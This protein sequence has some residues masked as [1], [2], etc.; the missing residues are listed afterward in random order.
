MLNYINAELY[1]NFNRKY[2]WMYT[3]I[4]VALAI[5]A[6]IAFLILGV[7][8]RTEA[9]SAM[10]DFGIIVPTFIIA[11]F[12]DFVTA[13][14][15]KTDTVRNVLT[16]GLSRTKMVVGKII[17]TVIFAFIAQIIILSIFFVLYFSLYGVNTNV[18]NVIVLGFQKMLLATPLWIACIC[19]LTLLSFLIK[20]NNIAITLY[21]VI[22]IF[23]KV[24]VEIVSTFFWSKFDVVQN[25]LITNKLKDI[26]QEGLKQNNI[27]YAITMGIIYIILFTGLSI[28]YM[29][30]KEIK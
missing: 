19:M 8:S 25:I 23:D 24:A 11:G 26:V 4:F 17:T 13:E 2:F 9:L 7:D 15:N 12:V 10:L 20:N 5:L 3:S 21:L 1:R 27:L 28:I 30:K 22:I 16:F 6:N 14:E 18:V 29:N